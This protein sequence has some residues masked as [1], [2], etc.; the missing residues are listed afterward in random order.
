MG[1]RELRVWQCEECGAVYESSLRAESCCK[2]YQCDTCG[3]FLEKY[4][5]RCD[6]CIEK[7]K[8]EKAKKLDIEIFDI[9]K[10]GRANLIF[11]KYER[12]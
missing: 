7:L 6:T 5:T 1:F 8:Y 3:K 11:L 9:R 4:R 10:Y 12:G 2:V